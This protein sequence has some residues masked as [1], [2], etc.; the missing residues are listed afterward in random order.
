MKTSSID[1]LILCIAWVTYLVMVIGSGGLASFLASWQHGLVI[2]AT[3]AFVLL[4]LG[5]W[6]GTHPDTKPGSST[7]HIHQHET[8]S[9]TDQLIHTLVHCLPL[10]LISALGVTSLGGHAFTFAATPSANLEAAQSNP[11]TGNN[12]LHNLVP[13]DLALRQLTIA[14]VYAS[15]MVLPAEIDVIGMI[16]RPTD[17]DYER[18]PGSLTREAVPLL[19]YRYQIT[20][21]A[22]DATPIFLALNGLDPLKYPNDTWVTVKG[23]LT[24]PTPPNNI[25]SLAVIS[26]KPVSTPSEQYL[27]RPLY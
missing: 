27:N 19:L 21:C 14:D 13:K 5:S 12:P 22:A 11:P 15:K 10:F 7:P 9:P 20:C 23:R 1:R 4:M 8:K 25:G 6:W 26:A 3:G 17:A 2:G 16:Y 18:L 24:P